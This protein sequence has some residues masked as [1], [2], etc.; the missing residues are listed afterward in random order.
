MKIDWKTLSY[1]LISSII[2]TELSSIIL[3]ITGIIQVFPMY[4]DYL[5]Q[6]SS[7][8]FPKYYDRYYDMNISII[9][10]DRIIDPPFFLSLWFYKV[11]FLLCL[12]V[13]TIIFYFLIDFLRKRKE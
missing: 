8:N 6:F 12:I 3:T 7:E 10:A 13:L 5:L 11:V 2:V 9:L 1:A 4:F